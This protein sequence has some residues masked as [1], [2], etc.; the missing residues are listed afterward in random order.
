[1]SKQI[2]F[3]PTRVSTQSF[4][5][6]S[7]QKNLWFELDMRTAVNGEKNGGMTSMVDEW[8]DIGCMNNIIFVATFGCLT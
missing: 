5:Y 3:V 7:E 1:M 8:L 4:S 2:D 6:G